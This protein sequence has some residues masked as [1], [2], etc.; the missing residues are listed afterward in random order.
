MGE[1]IIE[2]YYGCHTITFSYIYFQIFTYKKSNHFSSYLIY[3]SEFRRLG[4]FGL[5]LEFLDLIHYKMSIVV[6]EFYVLISIDKYLGYYFH[7]STL[8][9]MIIVPR[10]RF[11]ELL[12]PICFLFIMVMACVASCFLFLLILV[13]MIQMYLILMLRVIVFLFHPFDIIFNNFHFFVNLLTI[14]HK[15]FKLL[16]IYFIINNF[17]E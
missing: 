14:S 15:I 17:L 16:I 4:L 13:R 3:Y 12:S 2:R 7:F 9:T 11:L 6:E 5:I 10:R 8:H 1:L